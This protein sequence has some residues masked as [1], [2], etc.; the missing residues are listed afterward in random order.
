M[1]KRLEVLEEYGL[2]A[3]TDYV[4]QEEEEKEK[5]DE[6]DEQWST[7]NERMWKR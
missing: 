5:E 4:H 7:R 1:L 3:L 6:S 2:D